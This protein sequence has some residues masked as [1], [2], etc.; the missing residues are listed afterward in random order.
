MKGGRS[1]HCLWARTRKLA[2]RIRA[3]SRDPC[4]RLPVDPPDYPLTALQTGRYLL[5]VRQIN[6]RVPERLLLEIDI[7]RGLVPRNPWLLRILEAREPAPD[8]SEPSDDGLTSEQR[9]L[10]KAIKLT[11]PRQ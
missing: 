5:V 2:V 8:K 3:Q 4:F 10:I 6:L 7:E 11:E 1:E 9:A